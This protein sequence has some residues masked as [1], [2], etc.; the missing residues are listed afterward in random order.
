MLGEVGVD[1]LMG[2]KI[3]LELPGIDAVAVKGGFG[4][5]PDAGA[6]VLGSEQR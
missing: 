6:H 5:R 1:R 3:L 2:D 4:L